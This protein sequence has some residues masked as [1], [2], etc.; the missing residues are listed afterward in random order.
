MIQSFRHKGLAALYYEDQTK[1]V[2]Q[3]QAKRLRQI[4]S[5]LETAIT[6][7]D[8]DAPGL[9]LHPLKGNMTG[10]YAVSV[11]GNWRV[12]FRFEEGNVEDVD[13]VDYH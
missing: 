3:A 6:I 2:L 12:I 11:S 4:L 1:G 8:M 5:L 9:K 7:Q 10:F 13:L